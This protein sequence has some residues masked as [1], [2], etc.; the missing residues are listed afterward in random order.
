MVWLSLCPVGV[1]LASV[2]H[3]LPVSVNEIVIDGG[4]LRPCSSVHGYFT[5]LL[6]PNNMLM[7]TFQEVE[8]FVGV[9]NHKFLLPS[10]R[11]SWNNS[12]GHRT[13]LRRLV[14]IC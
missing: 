9:N 5:H 8:H 10:S 6:R 7:G 12:L 11:S 14:D 13:F 3:L 4:Q 1:L 2:F